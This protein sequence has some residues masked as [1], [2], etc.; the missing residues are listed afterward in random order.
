MSISCRPALHG[1]APFGSRDRA[2]AAAARPP[3]RASPHPAQRAS[4]RSPR[5]FTEQMYAQVVRTMDTGGASPIS[6]LLQAKSMVE[7]EG[8]ECVAVVAGDSVASLDS[9][10]FARRADILQDQ[11]QAD[12]T[13]GHEHAVF[14]SPVLRRATPLLTESSSF[15][16]QPL[17][18][19][20]SSSPAAD[21]AT[22]DRCR[23][24]RTDTR[25]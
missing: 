20:A 18:P 24:S 14:P 22:L 19:S 10:E 3:L 1:S 6:M 4:G 7:R 9:G 13:E 15:C 17:V 5:P 11:A 8:C 2:S 16:R 21:R 12:G 23:S 25:T